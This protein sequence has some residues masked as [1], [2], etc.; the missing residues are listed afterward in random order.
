MRRFETTIEIDAP[1][2]RVWAIISDVERWHEWTPSITRIERL[3]RGPMRV[4]SKARVKQP[5]L[6]ASTY[7]I[8]IWEP[9]RGFDWVT[10]S[11]GV[12]GVGKHWIEPVDGGSRVTLGVEF[13]GALAGV[14]GW[15][16]GALTTRYINLEAQGLKQR[17]E[18]HK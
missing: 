8:T 3:D 17:A 15:L 6:A 4:G 11:G 10:R 18:Q 13:S 14:I 9:N 12:T 7:E 1:P 16:F 2:A 5:K